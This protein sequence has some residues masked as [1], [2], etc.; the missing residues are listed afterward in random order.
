MY[1]NDY[2]RQDQSQVKLPENQSV[3][4]KMATEEM[5]KKNEFSVFYVIE[6]EIVEKVSEVNNEVTEW[7]TGAVFFLFLGGY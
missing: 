1:K 7:F 6:K 5:R 3:W 2:Y 4:Q